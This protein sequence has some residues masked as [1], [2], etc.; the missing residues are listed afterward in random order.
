MTAVT[1][2]LFDTPEQV[3]TMRSALDRRLSEVIDSGVF[4]FGPQ[5][6]AFE[7][8]FAAYLG[9]THVVGVANGTD[10]LVI[11]LQALGVKPGDDVVV[12]SFTFFATAEAVV[13]VGARPVFCDIDPATFCVT[14]ETVERALT[15]ATRALVPVHLFGMPAPMGELR[16]LAAERKLKLLEDAA[17]A[18][19]ARLDGERTGSLGDAATFSFFPSKN[20]FC[21]G[22]GGAIA[23]DD[24]QVAD[25][26]RLLRLHGSRE[27]QTYLMV[28]C[29]SRLDAIQAAVLREALPRLD[30]WNAARRDLASA[31]E[32]SGLGELA[33]LPEA[34]PGSEPVHHMYVVRSTE[35]DRLIEVLLSAGVEA[36]PCYP[37]PVHRQP[38]MEPYAHGVELPGTELASRESL[39]LP[40]G[41]MRGPELAGS[42][43]EALHQSL[44]SP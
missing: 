42:V 27:K 22:D 17:Q 36:R 4:V 37:V 29:N 41:P 30:G 5:V 13:N 7:R 24:E 12:P 26:A 8:E 38:A 3:A 6:A 32:Q 15:K 19:G 33:T 20:L 21:L 9:V 14:A 18:A 2:R 11:A 1:I 43:V 34:V 25:R 10:A 40:M 35:R 39:A 31:Y 23:T 16:E 28:G 44:N